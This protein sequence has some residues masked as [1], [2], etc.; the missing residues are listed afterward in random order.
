[1]IGEVVEEV[2]EEVSDAVSVVVSDVM[3]E[4]VQQGNVLALYTPDPSFKAKPRVKGLN[5][6]NVTH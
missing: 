1:M 5:Y 2:V 3:S 6:S 4:R